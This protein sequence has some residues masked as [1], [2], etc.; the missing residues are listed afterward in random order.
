[1][2]DR[3][4]RAFE[5]QEQFIADASH[6]LRTPLAVAKSSLQA[7]A[8]KGGAVDDLQQ[9][10]RDALEDLSRMQHVTEQLLM[11]ARLGRD[12]NTQE[13]VE[14]IELRPLLARLAQRYEAL[15]GRTGGDVVVMDVPH[16]TIPGH[17]TMLESLFGNLI[18]NAIVHGPPSG[19]VTIRG[20]VESGDAVTVCVHDEGGAVS[21]E[22]L[23]HLF[24]RFYRTDR[25]RSRH[26]GGT[27]LGP[28][29]ARE[30]T[31]RHEGKIWM[32]SS[33]DNGTQVLVRLPRR[34]A[35]PAPAAS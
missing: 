29:I 35:G 1:M 28:A 32:E 8:V 33:P 20:A 2:L 22:E 13:A 26:T 18:E 7:A 31:L 4:R 27:G 34:P 16:A 25:S 6:E 14:D 21:P 9:A 23:P 30:I 11:L 10:I 3:L 12:S 17:T 15:A 24:D 5:T 19:T